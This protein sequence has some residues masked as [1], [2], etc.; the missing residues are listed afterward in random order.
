MFVMTYEENS[1]R[2]AVPMPMLWAYGFEDSFGFRTMEDHHHIHV[3]ALV[4][5][6]E[7]LGGV[8]PSIEEC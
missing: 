1:R 6:R 2:D 4:T 8:N 3:A 7:R 5:P